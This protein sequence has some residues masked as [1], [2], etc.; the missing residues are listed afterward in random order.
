MYLNPSI[1]FLLWLRTL[2]LLHILPKSR[3]LFVN[4]KLHLS[5]I[6][7]EEDPERQR[8]QVPGAVMYGQGQNN[9]HLASKV[10]KH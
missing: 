7:Q 6:A 8:L 5:F 9:H 10:L 4:F 1:Y 2:Y 3:K